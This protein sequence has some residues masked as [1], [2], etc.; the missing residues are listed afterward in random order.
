MLS[1]SLIDPCED[2]LSSAIAGR[3]FTISATR[4]ALKLMFIIWLQLLGRE[5]DGTLLQ[6]SCLKNPMDGGVW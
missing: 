1:V 2:S 3:F 5:G 4:K 6:Y